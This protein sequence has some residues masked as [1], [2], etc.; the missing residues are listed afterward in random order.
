MS[1]FHD[2]IDL[3]DHFE[4]FSFIV[5]LKS[6]VYWVPWHK[7]PGKA[8]FIPAF[9][10]WLYSLFDFMCSQVKNSFPQV[11]KYG[12]RI[13]LT[14]FITLKAVLTFRSHEKSF[15]AAPLCSPT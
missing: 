12:N 1:L 8:V 15:L 7:G 5:S 4:R 10:I 2:I 9:S 11:F 6:I 14:V 3:E 13:T